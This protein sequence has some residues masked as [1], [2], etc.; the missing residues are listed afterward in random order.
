MG[1]AGINPRARIRKARGARLQTHAMRLGTERSPRK[2]TTTAAPYGLHTRKSQAP[3][4]CCTS[5][6]PCSAV[7]TLLQKVG[8]LPEHAEMPR[9]REGGAQRSRWPSIHGDLTCHG[10]GAQ[11]WGWRGEKA[12][13]EPR[14][15]SSPRGRVRF[16][17][18][19]K[20]HRCPGAWDP[21]ARAQAEN[22]PLWGGG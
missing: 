18:G 4:G 19:G 16:Q 22:V 11:S 17:R 21:R 7:L 5:S 13:G 8:V 9:E 1:S 10:T 3:E 20:M 12:P 6:V 14:V 15:L 2:K